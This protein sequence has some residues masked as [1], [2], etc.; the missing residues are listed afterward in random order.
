MDKNNFTPLER[1]ALIT[2]IK[3]FATRKNLSTYSDVFIKHLFLAYLKLE[4]ED[5]VW[6]E[7]IA[8]TE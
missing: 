2:F 3:E 4:K 8:Y 1:K 5:E 6:Q 7:S